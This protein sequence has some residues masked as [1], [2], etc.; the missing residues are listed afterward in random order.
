MSILTHGGNCSHDENHRQAG[1]VQLP[2]DREYEREEWENLKLCKHDLNLVES[3]SDSDTSEISAAMLLGLIHSA[4]MKSNDSYDLIRAFMLCHDAKLFPP[5]WVLG[6]L[7]SRFDKWERANLA[8]DN[9]TL[10]EIFN[11]GDKTAWRDRCY[12]PV[13]LTL[14]NEYLQLKYYWGINDEFIFKILEIRI[15]T[16]GIEGEENTA[17]ISKVFSSRTIKEL[18]KRFGWGQTFKVHKRIHD[19]YWPCMTSEGAKEFFQ[20]F[21]LEAQRI[22]LKYKKREPTEDYTKG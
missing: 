15:N 18:H 2:E 13:Y 19:E 3:D 17:H 10:D 21:P 16:D 7:F 20:R 8:G 4:Y 14:E 5:P 11:A 6:G 1:Y 9:R 12:D 22:I